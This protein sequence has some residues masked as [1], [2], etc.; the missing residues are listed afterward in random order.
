MPMKS[1]TLSRRHWLA[2]LAAASAT[3]CLPRA[4]AAP[5]PRKAQIAI[6]FDLEMSMHYPQR[7]ITEWNFRKG[8]L[9]Q[10]TKDYAV[11]AAKI[12]RERGGVIHFFCVGRVLEQPDVEWLKQLHA[13]GHP[14]GNHTYDH[15]NVLATDAVGTQFRFQRSPWLVEGRTAHDVIDENVKLT[16]V[17]LKERCGIEVAGFRTPGGFQTGLDGREDIQDLLK[18]QGFDWISSKYPKHLA[19]DPMVDPGPEVFADMIRSHSTAQPYV[20]PNGLI[21]VPM[22]A[23]SDVGAFRSN[24]WKRPFF[25]KAIQEGVAWAIETGSVY[26]FLCHPS[27]MLVEDPDFETVKQI[28]DQVA[29]AGDRAEIVSLGTIADRVRK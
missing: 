27:C 14:I 25:L 11:E 7:G 2:G 3:A 20:Y 10:P 19:G 24:F 21:E 22:N 9:D 17:G 28:C 6:T 8:D 26:D 13:T 16:T 29:Q 12:V 23:I 1:N 15:V 5:A 18:A 4:W